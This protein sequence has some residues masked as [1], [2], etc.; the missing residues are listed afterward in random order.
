MNRVRRAVRQ[1]RDHR[2]ASLSCELW[3]KAG[4]AFPFGLSITR[5]CLSRIVSL[6]TLRAENSPSFSSSLNLSLSRQVLDPT[7]VQGVCRLAHDKS[8]P[9]I[10]NTNMASPTPIDNKTLRDL[11]VKFIN[12]VPPTAE[13][14]KLAPAIKAKLAEELAN[15]ED[16]APKWLLDMVKA[17]KEEVA[18][19]EKK[20]ADL[21]EQHMGKLRAKAKAAAYGKHGFM[22]PDGGSVFNAAFQLAHQLRAD[23]MVVAKNTKPNYVAHRKKMDAN[24]DPTSNFFVQM[25]D[26]E[27]AKVAQ[28]KEHEG[29]KEALTDEGV[30]RYGEVILPPA[31]HLAPSVGFASRH[32]EVE[33]DPQ[34]EKGSGIG[35]TRCI[36]DKHK[37]SGTMVYDDN[38]AEDRRVDRERGTRHMPC[39]P[40]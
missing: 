7:S 5:G 29:M 16:T 6:Q 27:E 30:Y 39:W 12:G 11:A 23:A 2:N 38:D 34:I 37:T 10:P 3:G 25:L 28:G 21:E 17:D 31:K 19:L 8:P 33:S 15:G 22:D 14:C 18:A 24:W 40:L 13:E 35:S 20:V 32:M 9:L 4:L 36:Q 26:E 1:P